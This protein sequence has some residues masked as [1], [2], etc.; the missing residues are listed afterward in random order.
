[1][2]TEIIIK[3]K[4]TY[5]RT[6]TTTTVYENNNRFGI[7]SGPCE[8]VDFDEAEFEQLNTRNK[9]LQTNFTNG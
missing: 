9:Q 4:T 1:M 6:T 3:T 8:F 5:R 7:D 2:A